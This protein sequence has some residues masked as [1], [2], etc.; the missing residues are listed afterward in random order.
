[1]EGET[2]QPRE[3]RLRG[4][5]QAKGEKCATS[6]KWAGEGVFSFQYYDRRRYTV[7]KGSTA[8]RT[9]LLVSSPKKASHSKCSSIHSK[10]FPRVFARKLLVFRLHT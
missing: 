9:E 5:K 2:K 4:E 6:S 7:R 1:M 3:S 8:G 10:T